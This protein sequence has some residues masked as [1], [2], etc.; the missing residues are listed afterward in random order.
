MATTQTENEM[1]DLAY[2]AGLI[3]GEGSFSFGFSCSPS[4]RKYVT[5]RVV[6]S[7]QLNIAMIEGDEWIKKLRGIYDH[8]DI[9]NY[10]WIEHKPNYRGLRLARV[11]VANWSNIVTVCRLTLPYLTVKKK[12]AEA[13]IAF[14]PERPKLMG[15]EAVGDHFVRKV[16]WDS[17]NILLDLVDEIRSMNGKKQNVVQTRERITATLKSMDGQSFPSCFFTN[18]PKKMYR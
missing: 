11:H 9:K 6:F 4:C 16:N 8:F 18:N 7:P 14:G 13:F 3:D 5:G 2:L 1:T 10:L 17:A 15:R 12:H